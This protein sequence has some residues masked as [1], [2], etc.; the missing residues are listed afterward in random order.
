MRQSVTGRFA[1]CA[2]DSEIEQAQAALDILLPD[3][4]VTLP[5]LNNGTASA[6]PNPEL[7]FASRWLPGGNYLLAVEEIPG[8]VKMLN[9]ILNSLDDE[10][11]VGYWWHPEWLPFAADV[12]ANALVIDQRQ[13]PGQGP[14]GQFDHEGTTAFD[15]AGSLT[16]FVATIADAVEHQTDFKYF[17]PTVVDGRLEW[18]I[19]LG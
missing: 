5:R 16:E 3:P 2:A 7:Q 17:R 8:H 13:G 18:E 10:T 19:V 6:D 4:L 9:E 12:S 15:W 1:R 11:A 14:V